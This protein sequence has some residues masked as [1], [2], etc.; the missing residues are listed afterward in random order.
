MEDERKAIWY[1]LEALRDGGKRWLRDSPARN[2]PALASPLMAISQRQLET[3]LLHGESGKFDADQVIQIEP[4]FREGRRAALQCK[5]HFGGQHARCWFYLGIWVKKPSKG[6]SSRR[7]SERFVGF[8]F[9]PPEPGENHNYFHSQPCRT[10][11]D[12]KRITGALK[13]PERN[14]TWPLPATSSLELLLCLVLSVH[15]MKGLK[16]MAQTF[17]RDPNRYRAVSEAIERVTKRAGS[18]PT[19]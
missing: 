8:R 19:G 15:G 11:A 12:R 4:P 13:M 1:V 18:S 6:K 2:E 10:M 7:R 17:D 9:E 14:P 16:K 3:Y 5:W